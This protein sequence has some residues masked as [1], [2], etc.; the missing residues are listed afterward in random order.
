MNLQTLLRKLAWIGIL[1]LGLV[2]AA[3]ADW[4]PQQRELIAL[5]EAWIAAEVGHDK[6]ALERILDDRFLATFASSGE[7]IDRAA[8]VAWIMRSHIDPFT[9]VNQ[10]VEIHGDAALV[11]S[12]MG[13]TKFTWVAVTKSGR[14]VVI[15][16]TFSKITKKP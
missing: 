1:Q 13:A 8:Y 16:E 2:G 6:A 7:T 3:S 15:S 5:S 14:W 4:S 10:V 12:T 9:V 11:I